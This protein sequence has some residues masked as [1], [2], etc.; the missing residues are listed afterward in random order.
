MTIWILDCTVF[1]WW[2]YLVALFPFKLALNCIAL[3][4]STSGMVIVLK[5][6]KTMSSNLENENISMLELE[7]ALEC[8]ICLSVPPSTPIHQ[9]DNGHL[10]CRN[11]RSRLIDCPICR[12]K[13][14]IG[15]NLLAEK[16]LEKIPL[17]CPYS[18]LGCQVKIS[19]KDVENHGQECHLR[20]VCC[21][22]RLCKQRVRFAVLVSYKIS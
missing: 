22:S 21:P 2:L 8:V 12:K 6:Q 15:R 17:R 13:L 3:W 10:F 5:F 7:E 1:R 18:S 11:C 4:V 20:E 14:G 16:L 9:C 19:Q